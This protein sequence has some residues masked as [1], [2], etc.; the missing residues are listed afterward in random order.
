MANVYKIVKR[1]GRGRH[2]TFACGRWR[3]T[4]RPNEWAKAPDADGGLLA[5]QS[6]T[7]A[8][9][10]LATGALRGF[11]NVEIWRAEAEDPVPLPSRRAQWR[12]DFGRCWAR[13]LPARFHAEWPRNTV[14]YRYLCLVERVESYRREEK[15]S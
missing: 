2:S 13:K 9:A 7:D 10:W 15:K 4:Y 3:V 6:L 1:T 14:A 12:N 5:F 8:R 11:A